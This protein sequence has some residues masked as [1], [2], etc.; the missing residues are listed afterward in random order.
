[1]YEEIYLKFNEFH[2]IFHFKINDT[3]TFE[4]V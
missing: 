1:M 2:L 3:E 4:S